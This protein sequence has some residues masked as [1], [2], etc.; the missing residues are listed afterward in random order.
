MDEGKDEKYLCI[1]GMDEKYLYIKGMD[2]KYL[3]KELYDNIII[4][5]QLTLTLLQLQNC[6]VHQVISVPGV[7]S[8]VLN[9]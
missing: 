5:T 1:E 8:S 7:I 3:W 4:L 6:C 2:E 9:L